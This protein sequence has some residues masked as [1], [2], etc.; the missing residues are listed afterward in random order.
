MW[1]SV[2]TGSGSTGLR[3]SQDIHGRSQIDTH[4]FVHRRPLG[5]VILDGG[6]GNGQPRR[7]TSFGQLFVMLSPFAAP[8]LRL[9]DRR[10]LLQKGHQALGGVLS[11]ED[12]GKLAF[13]EAQRGFKRHVLHA[14]IGIEAALDDQRRLGDEL[15]AQR[16]DLGVE[17]VARHAAR[18]QAQALGGGGILGGRRSGSAP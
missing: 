6:G 5:A 17:L 2:K 12:P 13:E 7:P 10:S 1:D 8:L 11:A 14:V 15:F 9:P 18:D 4:R 16:R 3:C